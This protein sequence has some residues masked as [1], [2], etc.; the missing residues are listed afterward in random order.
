MWINKKNQRLLKMI[1]KRSVVTNFLYNMIYQISM[2]IFP[3]ITSPY[4]SRVLGA[5]NIGKYTYTFSIAF[6]FYLIGMLGIYNY[7]SRSIASIDNDNTKLI[8][9]FSKIYFFQLFSTT[10]LF[11][12]YLYYAFYICIDNQS[13]VIAHIP[14]VFTAIISIDWLF[15]GLEDFKIIVF[16]RTIVRIIS[17]VLVFLFVRI[18]ADLLLYAYIISLTE[19]LGVIY[20]WFY[21]PNYFHLVKVNLKTV[22]SSYKEIILLFIPIVATS[23]YRYMDKI[24]LGSYGFITDV[25]QLDYAEKIIMICLGCMTALGNVMLP[26]MSSLVANNRI[27]EVKAFISKS[28]DFAFFASCGLAFGLASFGRR[29]AVVYFGD[30]FV[31]CGLAITYLSITVVPIAVANV[32]RTQY[33]IPNSRDKENLYAVLSG[34][35]VNFLLVTYLVP[36]F[37][38]VGAISG[39]IVAEFS[40]AFLQCIL[41]RNELNIIDLV[42]HA[43]PF[44]I[45]GFVMLCMESLIYNFTNDDILGLSFQIL[46]GVFFYCFAAILYF[47]KSNNFMYRYFCDKIIAY[48]LLSKYKE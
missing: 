7:G 39:T 48:D 23:I 45:I 28:M 16:R 30:K 17:T 27:D 34:A 4:L 37:G 43:K 24:I 26:K 38:L 44:I 35:I 42:S 12:S 3:L 46:F 5:E 14:Y 2:I 11:F 20:V 21:L 25:G 41:L 40:V 47:K 19:L 22:L 33:L 36:I 6:Y 29:L 8:F 1:K 32:L 31:N 10:I 13:L 15:S 9:T 18:D